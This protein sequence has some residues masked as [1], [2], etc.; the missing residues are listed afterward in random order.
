MCSS[1]NNI[2]PF[3]FGAC[4]SSGWKT[5]LETISANNKP[6]IIEREKEPASHLDNQALADMQGRWSRSE[7][8]LQLKL[9]EVQHKVRN[10]NHMKKNIFVFELFPF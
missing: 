8:A 7:L 5:A 10:Y 1:F 9:E 6:V 2:F 3:Y 4:C